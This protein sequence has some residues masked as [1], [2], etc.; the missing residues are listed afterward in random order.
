MSTRFALRE[1]RPVGRSRYLVT[2]AWLSGER[3]WWTLVASRTSQC[4]TSQSGQ[5]VQYLSL[6]VIVPVEATPRQLSQGLVVARGFCDGPIDMHFHSVASIQTHSGD[7]GCGGTRRRRVKENCKYVPACNQTFVQELCPL[8]STHPSQ[9]RSA[10]PR[11][12]TRQSVSADEQRRHHTGPAQ[13][14]RAKMKW[15]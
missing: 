13:H 2:L 9:S 7:K 10:N 15:T 1:A 11:F 6:G 5:V 3:S 12:G 8:R 4:T 14:F